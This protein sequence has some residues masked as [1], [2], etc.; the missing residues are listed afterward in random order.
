MREEGFI[1]DEAIDGSFAIEKLRDSEPG[2]YE[3]V[4]LDLEMPV[5][6]G[7]ETTRIIRNFKDSRVAQIPIVA[8]TADALPEEKSHAFNCGVNAY[9]IKPVNMPEMLKV[10]MLFFRENKR[11]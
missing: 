7:Y 9:L 11:S 3:L 10:L 2:T 1:V 8:L 6:D 5:M 4:I